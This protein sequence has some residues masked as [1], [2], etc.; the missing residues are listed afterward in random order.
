M[1]HESYL[2][3]KKKLHWAIEKGRFLKAERGREKEIIKNGYAGLCKVALLRG[4]QRAYGEDYLSSADQVIA[5]WL[6]KG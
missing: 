2:A 3:N 6:V 4:T 1:I 5:C